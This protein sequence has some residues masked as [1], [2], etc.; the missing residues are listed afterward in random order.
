MKTRVVTIEFD[1]SPTRVMQQVAPYYRPAPGEH[2]GGFATHLGKI[3]EEQDKRLE[4]IEYYLADIYDR[5][6][7]AGQLSD[8]DADSLAKINA[9]MAAIE[10]RSAEP[11][12]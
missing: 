6:R 9:L 3:L 7:K 10:A 1:G 12:G 5:F 11:T 4:R 2:I 8:A